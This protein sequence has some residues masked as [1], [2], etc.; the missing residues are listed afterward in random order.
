MKLAASRAMFW[1]AS[2]PRLG[3][4]AELAVTRRLVLLLCPFFLFPL[5]EHV[6]TVHQLPSIRG[7]RRILPVHQCGCGT[8]SISVPGKLRNAR[9]QASPQTCRLGG[10]VWRPALCTLQGLLR[11]LK[12][13]NH[14]G[15]LL[16]FPVALSA[17]AQWQALDRTCSWV[18][19]PRALPVCARHLLR[20]V[21]TD[22]GH[23]GGEGVLELA[24]ACRNL[25]VSKW[26]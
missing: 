10:C 23:R 4:T 6:V 9:P 21:H 17:A 3:N 12:F 18:S 24:L 26:T 13:E 25:R 11:P 8:W 2:T 14:C 5:R 1:T 7:V 15:S 20:P 16:S 19:H 22:M